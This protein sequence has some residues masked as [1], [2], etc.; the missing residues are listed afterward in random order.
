VV[1]A[2]HAAAKLE[3]VK[4]R[5]V[6]GRTSRMQEESRPLSPLGR[7]NPSLLLH[8]APAMA[9]LEAAGDARS[10][11]ASRLAVQEAVSSVA[12]VH[13]RAPPVH[14]RAPPALRQRVPALSPEH[15]GVVDS[16]G[17]RLGVTSY[18]DFASRVTLVPF[19]AAPRPL[20]HGGEWQG[21]R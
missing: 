20:G 9:A 21:R 18:Q 11:A 13:Q 12:A 5:P 6:R 15:E 7:R 17:S 1:G 4:V 19:P 3:R 10:G 16:G 8:K 14:Q 2:F